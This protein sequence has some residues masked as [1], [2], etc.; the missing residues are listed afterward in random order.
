MRIILILILILILT[1]NNGG[2]DNVTTILLHELIVQSI[3]GAGHIMSPIYSYTYLF[4]LH[5][6]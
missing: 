1:T 3:H 2:G 5:S 6:L 4:T